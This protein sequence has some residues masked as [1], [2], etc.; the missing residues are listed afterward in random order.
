M[1]SDAHCETPST[2]EVSAGPA[3]DVAEG[4]TSVEGWAEGSA[5]GVAE[6]TGRTVDE[7]PAPEQ[8]LEERARAAVISS[9]VH[10]DMRH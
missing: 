2:V 9:E 3:E 8:R 4:D 6:V 10:L 5:E 7:A 1:Q